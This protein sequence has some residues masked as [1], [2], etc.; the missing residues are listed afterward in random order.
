[1]K[2]KT[3]K[4]KVLFQEH[5]GKKTNERKSMATTMRK[6]INFPVAPLVNYKNKFGNGQNKKPG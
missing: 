4:L 2:K 6:L 3:N 5:H 1:M